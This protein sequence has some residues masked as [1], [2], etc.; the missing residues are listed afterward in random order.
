MYFSQ[1]TKACL[2]SNEIRNFR[3]MGGY[4]VGQL[5][6]E[7]CATVARKAHYTR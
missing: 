4:W 2:E 7:S 3:R 1:E 6:R 5:Y